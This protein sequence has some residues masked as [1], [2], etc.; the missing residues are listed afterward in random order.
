MIR[1]LNNLRTLHVARLCANF[2][3]GTLTDGSKKPSLLALPLLFWL[4]YLEALQQ[5]QV[6]LNLS[7]QSHL[8]ALYE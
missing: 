8:V 3:Q 4:P 6:W 1:I 2:Y 5:P 7:L